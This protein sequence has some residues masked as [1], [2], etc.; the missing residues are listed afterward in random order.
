[1]QSVRRVSMSIEISESAADDESANLSR[2]DLR[3]FRSC[4]GNIQK[5]IRERKSAIKPD[6]SLESVTVSCVDVLPNSS[7]LKEEHVSPKSLRSNYLSNSG[8]GETIGSSHVMEIAVESDPMITSD[9]SICIMAM[10]KTIKPPATPNF[11]STAEIAGNSILELE[12]PGVRFGA[13]LGATSAVRPTS[14][15]LLNSNSASAIPQLDISATNL[16]NATKSTESSYAVGEVKTHPIKNAVDLLFS[17]A[18]ASS[19]KISTDFTAQREG[20]HSIPNRA[21]FVSPRSVKTT[22]IWI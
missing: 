14:H 17:A 7:A 2:G 1:V 20:T 19:I 8:V 21:N 16:D 12:T 22:G 6:P 18:N 11:K 4:L 13:P 3:F 15:S 10:E 5:S 9:A